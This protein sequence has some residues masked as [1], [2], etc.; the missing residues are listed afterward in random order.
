MPGHPGGIRR[1]DQIP[2]PSTKVSGAASDYGAGGRLLQITLMRR[3]RRDT[4]VTTVSQH[5][6]CG[7]GCSGLPLGVLGGGISW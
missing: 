1:G 3:D 6:Q 4:G 5:L 7:G 2:P